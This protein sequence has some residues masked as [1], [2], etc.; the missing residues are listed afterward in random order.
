MILFSSHFLWQLECLD[1]LLEKIVAKRLLCIVGRYE[2]I[3]GTQFCRQSN[4]STIDTN[5][6]CTWCT[7][8]LE[9]KH[10]N[11][12]TDLQHQRLLWLYKPPMPFFR[13]AKKIHTTRIPQMDSKL[14]RQVQSSNMC[15]WHQRKL[16]TSKEW[17]L[18]RIICLTHSN[19]IL[20]SRPSRGV[21]EC[22][23][24]SYPWTSKD[25][26][27][28]QHRYSDICWWW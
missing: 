6:I 11:I 7:H 13:D 12:C 4:S 20:L 10:G 26:K 1:K 5:D 16:K 9:P 17:N 24:S 27:A 15:W 19:I 8:C 23:C 28:N 2:L 21:L 18:P 25:Y 22:K 14:P 3:L